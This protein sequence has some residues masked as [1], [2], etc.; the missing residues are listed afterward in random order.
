MVDIRFYITVQ[1]TDRDV[2][3]FNFWLVE[4]TVHLP[5]APWFLLPLLDKYMEILSDL[6][7]E[8]L[9]LLHFFLESRVILDLHLLSEGYDIFC[10]SNSVCILD[11]CILKT[12]TIEVNVSF[13]LKS[14]FFFDFINLSLFFLNLFNKLLLCFG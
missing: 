13:L 12:P 2:F 11:Q 9:H 10:H 6:G 1:V 14:Q 5:I 3:A 8:L 7:M 4:N